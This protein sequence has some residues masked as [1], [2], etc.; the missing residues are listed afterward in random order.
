MTDL[1][2]F[3]I[4]PFDNA[5]SFSDQ[6]VNTRGRLLVQMNP[7][8]ANRPDVVLQM[9]QMPYDTPTL[10]GMS[11]QMYGMMT[12]DSLRQQ[13][14][15]MQPSAQRAFLG[16]MS[17]GQQM[18]L[19]SM[20]YKTPDREDEGPFAQLMHGVGTLLKP[21]TQGVSTV[22]N[23]IVGGALG[24]LNW[25]GNWPG[26]LY[27]TW[28]LMGDSQQW[29]GALGAIAGGIAA[30]GLIPFTGGG[31][32][33]ALGLIGSGALVGGTI[34]AGVT[35]PLDWV[36]AFNS[37]WD[38]ERTFDL[39][40]QRKARGILEDPRMVTLAHELAAENF[41]LFDFAKEIASTAQP[42][43]DAQLKVI[44]RLAGQMA[45]PGSPE[46]QQVSSAMV[47]A[48]G[49]TE[50]QRAVMTLQKGKISPGRDLADRF[51]DPGSTAYTFISGAVDATFTMAVDPTLF[52]SSITRSAKASRW[53][54]RIVEGMESSDIARRVIDV[55][56]ASANVRRYQ[57]HML[58]AVNMEHGGLQVVRSMFPA[59]KDQQLYN[60]LREYRKSQ[61]ALGKLPEGKLTMDGF[62]E[63]VTGAAGAEALLGGRGTVQAARGLV[64][65]EE[66]G[67]RTE[68]I[69]KVRLAARDFTNGLSD[70]RTLRRLEDWSKEAGSTLHDVAM[71]PPTTNDL[72]TNAGVVGNAE[73]ITRQSKA[74][75]RGQRLAT[76]EHGPLRPSYWG[77]HIAG[78]VGDILTSATTMSLAGRALAVTGDNAVRDVRAF[79]ELMRYTGMP[80]YARN[81][82]AEAILNADNT[83]DRM[84]AIHGMVASMMRAVGADASTEGQQIV[85]EFLER[86][87]HVYGDADELIINGHKTHVG[88]RLN[89]AADEIVVPDLMELFR[90]TNTGA[91]AKFLG[92]FE[93]PTLEPFMTKVWKPLVLLRLGFIPRAAG[94]EL[95]GALSRGSLDGMIQHMGAQYVSRRQAFFDAQAKLA[96]QVAGEI[97]K[98]SPQE[99]ELLNRG[100]YAML[101]GYVRPV[102]HMMEQFGFGSLAQKV[103][104]SHANWIDGVL[105]RGVWSGRT[106]RQFMGNL[107]GD[108]KNLQGTEGGFQGNLARVLDAVVMGGSHSARRLIFGGIDPDLIE[109]G[110][111]WAKLHSA[112]IMRELSATNAGPVSPLFD[113]TQ[114]VT[115]ME[116]DRKGVLRPVV[117]VNVRGERRMIGL[118][119]GGHFDHGLHQEWTHALHDPAMRDAVENI[120]P[121]I[122]PTTGAASQ[123]SD[124]ELDQYVAEAVFHIGRPI[125]KARFGDEQ[126]LR[127][128]FDYVL[129]GSND[130]T[131]WEL[132]L[133]AAE[134]AAGRR[135]RVA[136]FHTLLATLD[137]NEPH[138]LVDIVDALR[139]IPQGLK[140]RET[141]ELVSAAN[142]VAD[143]LIGSTRF[144]GWGQTL[145]PGD[146]AS[147]HWLT[148]LIHSEVART[149]RGRVGREAVP[150]M[151]RAF[152]AERDLYPSMEAAYHDI[153]T[154]VRSALMSPENQ[155]TAVEKMMRNRKLDAEGNY[156]GAVNEHVA[157]LYEVP[158][159]HG[160][161]IDELRA[162]STRP[163]LL[164]RNLSDIEHMLQGTVDD[165]MLTGN[166]ELAVELWRTKARLNGVDPDI[167]QRPMMYRA[168]RTVMDGRQHENLDPINT[169]VTRGN[170]AGD[171]RQG[172]RP[173]LWR[174]PKG[175]AERQLQ[176][177]PDE[178]ID[179]LDAWTYDLTDATMRLIMGR[180]E[181]F[182]TPRQIM[183]EN[184]PES[185]VYRWTGTGRDL[186]GT[187]EQVPLGTR[188]NYADRS[189][190]VDRQGRPLGTDADYFESM[191][192]AGSMDGIMW[193]GVGPIVRDVIDERAGT[194]LWQRRPA[195]LEAGASPVQSPERI[196]YRRA[197]VSDVRRVAANDLPTHVASLA[198][199]PGR[200]L[201][202]YE[203]MVQF[204]FDRAI[205][206]AIDAIVRR[207]M[208]FHAFAARYKTAKQA[209]GW[210]YDTATVER[211]ADVFR[212]HAAT[213]L[214]D[215]DYKDFN[216][217][218]DDVATLL[219][220]RTKQSRTREDAIAWLNG[221]HQRELHGLAD[222][223]R[224]TYKGV[225]GGDAA[226][227]LAAA[228][229]VKAQDRVLLNV[230]PLALAARAKIDPTEMMNAI[231]R[232]L[233]PGAMDEPNWLR[234]T[235]VQE[236]IANNALLKSIDQQQAWNVVEALHNNITH[237]A[238]AV[239]EHAAVAA[240]KDVLPFID[241]HEFRTQFADL[242][243]GLM[244]FWYAEENFMKRWARGLAE[245]GPAVIRRM[246]L[247]YMG[248]RHAGIVR[249]DANGRD[250]FVYPGSG[251]LA[252]AIGKMVPSLSQLGGV[253]VMF[254]TPTDS[255]LPGL[256]SRPG[257]PS[258][259]PLVSVPI[260]LA[261]SMF[262][263]LQPVQRALLGDT[264]SNP[265][266]NVLD[267]IVPSHIRNLMNA[268][269]AGEENQRYSSAMLA[270]IAHLEANGKGLPDNAGPWEIQRFLDD[271]RQH[272]R[273]AVVAQAL[274]GFLGPGPSSPI[275]DENGGHI[276]T[277][278]DNPL[279]VA[280]R[281]SGLGVTDAANILGDEYQRLV[282]LLGI[283]EGTAKFLEISKGTVKDMMNP[284][285]F[286]VPKR[287]SVSGAPIPAT[288][289]A[290]LYYQ[291]HKSYM[292]E[293]PLAAPYLLPQMTDNARSSY[294]YDQEVSYGLRQQQSPEQFLRSV[295]FK[296]SAGEYF[297][298]RTSFL[299]QI[300][301]AENSGNRHLASRLRES[302]NY[303]LTVYRAANPIFAEELASGDGRQ[304]RKNT[305]A[306]MRTLTEDP[307][308]PDSAQL[309][310]LRL[311]MQ[312][313]NT[314]TV[315]LTSLSA[316]NTALSRAK[317]RALKQTYQSYMENLVRENPNI[318]SFW[319]GVLQPESS[320]D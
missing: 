34:G 266:A 48:L 140:A 215:N 7:I 127:H 81:A 30:V 54:I 222:W 183:G 200:K 197:K 90:A 221:S 25:I 300:A 118:A 160:V 40:S 264:A 42:G 204:G 108:A 84:R 212:T 4:S 150:L 261:V 58:D 234:R 269:F 180:R 211:M 41:D 135:G 35:A 16:T 31:S 297:S 141:K 224:S 36:R 77:S 87:K 287:S 44:E 45:H 107:A 37:S 130:P 161:T 106:W 268:V 208:A 68:W 288:E 254:Q 253:N 229:R 303:N 245:Q 114:L 125:E 176:A 26:H 174:M 51:L 304:R 56:K 22:V 133:D 230:E 309:Q 39:P 156:I 165:Q 243:S 170:V 131:R 172:A 315:Q 218:A 162:A 79:T 267:A 82:V 123:L 195:T 320:L 271:V 99:Y 64:M 71:L 250:W 275:I 299:S 52:V 244:P 251:L 283:N 260:D 20:G 295:M 152:S 217:L 109:A 139:R 32:L 274:M 9:A 186:G 49:D 10:V 132:I 278:T 311:A 189:T 23:P 153:H 100:W 62:Y 124:A 187:L 190:Y 247:T 249:T 129:E 171:A 237:V 33:A 142:E 178:L 192:D 3:S 116:R 210:M 17:E 279:D 220:L 154:S 120:I 43:Q 277:V 105:R 305:I 185:P 207:P 317:V 223:A 226:V 255:I 74:Y 310:P 270:A 2:P 276:A 24:A 232:R 199:E 181:N 259:S 301:D 158:Q 18:A 293:L 65:L 122:R 138:D 88:L 69:R 113:H 96:D 117:H 265:N 78:K 21:I 167:V 258:F 146:E 206:P 104:A 316:E 128:L 38:G 159:L 319:T 228:R 6:D 202:M 126:V 318:M 67:P 285:A 272:A 47:N 302:M 27:R 173:T 198:L 184:G 5:S 8:M 148:T 201:N 163:D 14:E 15:G 13:L 298:M 19:K 214:A 11:G 188:I 227:A 257:T 57:Q 314:Y 145:D 121:R 235:D 194:M 286:T 97:V 242:G 151:N 307:Q 147:L 168:P 144:V 94:E 219:R 55:S 306:Q 76:S 155:T 216:L 149:A 134:Q 248:F 236:A 179:P 95:A 12:A 169:S 241:S 85:R 191:G 313:Y 252:E 70:G 284:L 182:L 92:I 246:Q 80:S 53:G 213:F 273:V 289:D 196:P 281:F 157:P 256:N 143:R 263:E 231:Q 312:A 91:T 136:G 203:R 225:E 308:A 75:E 209:A 101:P 112:S 115:Q 294:A 111:S 280:R 28:R 291:Q 98:L 238:D 102:A 137:P 50:F 177:T 166:Y 93:H 72:I 239:G 59:A 89:D 103:L 296:A 175:V 205:G 240:I 29:L 282:R 46:F 290:L 233:P 292:E 60:T 66:M 193:G 1:S 164:D 262:G 63:W 83:G 86:S 110:T 119:E 61:I 73:L